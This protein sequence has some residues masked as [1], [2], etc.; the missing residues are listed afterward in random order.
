[1]RRLKALGIYDSPEQVNTAIQDVSAMLSV[2][3]HALGIS[4]A[5]RWGMHCR[6]GLAQAQE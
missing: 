1:M 4:C 5:S 6:L 2:P 3:R